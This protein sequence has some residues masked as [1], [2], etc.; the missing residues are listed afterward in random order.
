MARPTTTTSRSAARAASATARR[1]ATLE[2]NVV[3]AT[4]AARGLDQFRDASSPH[5]FPRASG[6]RA[7]H[8]WNRRRRRGSPPR[9]ARAACASSVGIAEHRRRIELPVAGMQHRAAGRA[10]DQRVRFR[11]RMRH[12]Y[13]FDVERPDIE[14]AAERHDLDGDFRRAR[15]ARPLGF[16]Q[17]GGERR[18]ID[19]H[20]QPRPQIEQRAEMIL[21]RMRE[22]DAGEV[23]ALRDQIADVRQDQ[24]D[25]RQMLFRGKRHAEIDDQP[26]PPALVADPVD[27]QIHADLADAAERRKHQFL[28]R[29]LRH[30]LQRSADGQSENVAGGDRCAARPA[31][32][33]AASRPVEPV[34]AARKLALRQPHPN[35]RSPSPAARASQ[36]ARIVAK[37]S[38]ACH[39]ASRRSIAADSAAN[40]AS[41]ATTAP[42]DSRSVAGKSVSGG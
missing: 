30:Q 14:T 7:P 37:P 42:A 4:R 34:E 17:R 18:R 36:S 10:D 20:L 29:H 11:N 12:R 39:C 24:V 6:R 23:L 32:R 5:P 38:P 27:R 26:L 19:R 22:H 13:Q 25:A 33:D 3:T 31:A 9:R 15:L 35:D 28:L 8:W 2:A 21:V 41:G 40:S 16:E 1:R